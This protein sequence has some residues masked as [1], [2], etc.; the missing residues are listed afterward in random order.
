MAPAPQG[1]LQG[2]NEGNKA[3]ENPQNI[4][5]TGE[6]PEEAAYDPNQT[7]EGQEQANG[8]SP[9][10]DEMAAGSGE[11]EA[12]QKEENRDQLEDEDN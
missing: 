10:Q 6:A 8:E 2:Q 1:P 5:A 9:D 3:S 12:K 11:S 7:Q 4:P